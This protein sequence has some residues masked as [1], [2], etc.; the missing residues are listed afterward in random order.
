MF[1][2]RIARELRSLIGVEDARL[3]TTQ[4]LGEHTSAEVGI[5]RVG[6]IPGQD[7]TTEPVDDRDTVHEASLH[8]NVGDVSAPH[9]VRLCDGHV[10]QQVRIDLMI[11]RWFAHFWA[12]V[13]GL[14]AHLMHQPCYSFVI[15][16][17]PLLS[18]RYGDSSH[19][20][21]G[22]RR[23]LSVDRMHQSERR[24]IRKDRHIVQT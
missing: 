9:M 18:H 20:V 13:D 21:E 12:C 5:L 4:G 14:D 17:E 15:N 2:K 22:M 19:A 11:W 23:V 8:R 6:D 7:K 1:E 10:P 3:P 24:T 16:T